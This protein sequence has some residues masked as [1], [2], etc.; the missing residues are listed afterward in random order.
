MLPLIEPRGRG[1]GD[2]VTLGTLM[3][4]VVRR[5]P[6]LDI[7]PGSGGAAHVREIACHLPRAAA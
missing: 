4:G 7:R 6:H 3:A 2:P 5:C 1:D